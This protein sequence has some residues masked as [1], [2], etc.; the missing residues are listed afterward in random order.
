MERII[1]KKP[2][3]KDKLEFI[4]YLLNIRDSVEGFLED[5]YYDDFNEFEVLK[6]IQLG[7]SGLG[8][9]IIFDIK[10]LEEDDSG[11][12]FYGNYEVSQYTFRIVLCIKEIAVNLFEFKD[13]GVLIKIVDMHGEL[14]INFKGQFIEESAQQAIEVI[15]NLPNSLDVPIESIQH[16]YDEIEEVKQQIHETGNEREKITQYLEQLDDQ[17]VKLKE[18]LENVRENTAKLIL[19]SIKQEISKDNLSC[20]HSDIN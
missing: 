9:L 6:L 5:K 17:L 1:V 18:N 7:E 15:Q 3:H 10:Y 2:I 8:I 4:E 13:R 14:D 12:D 19:H 11:P 16:Y 20:F